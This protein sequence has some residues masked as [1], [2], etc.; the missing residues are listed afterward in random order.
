MLRLAVLFLI[1]L[2]FLPSGN[3]IAQTEREEWRQIPSPTDKTLRNLHFIDAQTGWAAGEDGT[4][5]HTSN[6]G[7]NW[8][9]QN[10][11]VQTFIVDVFFINENF[12]WAI[13]FRDTFPFGS[14]ILN[15]SDGGD[16]WIAEDYPDRNVYMNTVFFFDT[17][18]GW[19][20][21]TY[22]AGTT[23]GGATWVRA[24]VDSSMISGLPVFNFNFYT[25]QFGY[26]CGG[27]LD[28]AGVI[29]RTTN[30][31]E[32]WSA[33]GV[34]PDQVFDLY[35]KDSLNAI[36]LS[37]DPEGF[38]GIGDIKTTDA[39][40]SWTYEE[41]SLSGLSFAIDFR[42]EYEG[43]SASGFKFLFTSDKGESWIDKETPD[44][45]IIFDLVFVDSRNG[46]AVGENGVIL[47]Y[48]PGPVNVN[49]TGNDDALTNFIL[50]QNNPNPF[51][52]TTKIRYTIPSV[53]QS[54]VEGSFITL[55]VYDVL[56]NEVV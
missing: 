27:Y 28:L 49:E 48:I 44:S 5:I 33:R 35:I 21:G 53:T 19:I 34:S 43:W 32:S 40:T 12:G 26:A 15:T 3:S 10:S 47:K 41:L 55:K 25:R 11:T 6:G 20:G 24:D 51:N 14:I 42:T 30:S 50:Y 8:V 46:F 18:T 29:W 7:E 45:A 54:E 13:T 31:G 17:L 52:P 38:F 23:N 39:G 36:T 9:V 22:I 56:G 1:I 4:I 37:G 16:N 2:Y